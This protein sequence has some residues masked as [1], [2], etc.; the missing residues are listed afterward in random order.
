MLMRD[1][2]KIIINDYIQGD[3]LS[4]ENLD[5][6][7]NFLHEFRL[8]FG[9]SKTIWLYTGYKWSDIWSDSRIV[10]D[11]YTNQ[12]YENYRKRQQTIS[13]CDV[14]VDGRYIDS[15]RNIQLKYRGSENQRVI[16]IQK[17]I[18]QNHI[19]LYCD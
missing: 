19:T 3:P 5:K 18:K 2:E 15:Q 12:V 10:I 17:T 6:T 8:L 11:D 13:M 4:E 1:K 9:Q 7:L 14:V 16:D